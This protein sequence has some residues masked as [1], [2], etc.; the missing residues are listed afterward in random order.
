MN[1]LAGPLAIVVYLTHWRMDQARGS[2]KVGLWSEHCGETLILHSAV[3][4]SMLELLDVDLF[5]VTLRSAACFEHVMNALVSAACMRVNSCR[6]QKA[7]NRVSVICH[8]SQA[9]VTTSRTRWKIRAKRHRILQPSEHNSKSAQNADPVDSDRKEN[10]GDQRLCPLE[11]EHYLYDNQSQTI[12]EWLDLCDIDLNEHGVRWPRD[13]L[14]ELPDLRSQPK[15]TSDQCIAWQIFKDDRTA[16]LPSFEEL[17]PRLDV[18]SCRDAW[19][20]EKPIKLKEDRFEEFKARLLDETV[21]KIRLLNVP[22]TKEM[23]SRR[24]QSQHSVMVRETVQHFYG[25]GDGHSIEIHDATTNV[26]PKGTVTEVHHDSDPHI[27]TV[28]GEFGT[29]Y[30]Q[31]MKLWLLWKASESRRLATCYSDTAAALRHLGPCGYLIQYA[32]ESL[33]LPANLPHA[34]LSLSPHYLYGQTFHVKGRA[35]DPTTFELEISAFAKPLEAMGTVLTCYEEGLRDPDPRTR[36]IHVD[37]VIH[38]ISSEKIVPNQVPEESYIS[39]VVDVLKANGK[40]DGICGNVIHPE[41]GH[42]RKSDISAR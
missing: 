35:R 3:Q 34:A 15:H 9:H 16:H 2:C 13:E 36:A 24:S 33:L 26:T 18:E 23:V 6:A 27:S 7:L 25:V 42:T 14:D 1:Y 28:C 20:L 21:S 17:V 30:E 41:V 19:F 10:T 11:E 4:H 29:S 32:G 22:V 12:G 5:N 40:F 39:R 31:P 37:H 8:Q 38:M